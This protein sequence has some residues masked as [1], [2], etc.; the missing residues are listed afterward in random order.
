M[1]E[2]IGVSPG[3]GIGPAFILSDDKEQPVERAIIDRDVPR[4]IARFEEAIMT[5]RHQIKEIQEG[6]TDAIG[7]TDASILDAHLMVLDD[8]SFIEDVIVGLKKQLKNVETVVRLVA[9]KYADALSKVD[10]EYLRERAADIKDVARRILRNLHGDTYD[11][12]V[13]LE[14]KSLVVARD[15]APSEIAALRNDRVVG[16]ATDLGSRTSHTAIMARSLEI[17]AVMALRDVSTRV[18]SGDQVLID[19]NKGLLIIS[20]TEER[21][22]AYGQVV[23]AREHIRSELAG[24]R[25]EPA[26]TKD[27]HRIVLSA[28]IELPDDVDAALE[29]GANGVGLFRSEYLYLTREVLP[30]EDEQARAYGEVARRFESKPVIIRT[31][32]L[33]GDKIG[34]AFQI[35]RERNPFMGWRAIRFCLSHPAIFKTQLKAILRASHEGNVKLMYPMITSVEEVVDAN[36]ILEEA[37][38]ELSAAGVPFD[39]GM[40]VGV[41]IE[42]PSAALTADTIAPH[43]NFFSLGSNDLIQYTLAVDRGNEQIANLYKP[44]HPA[45]IKLIQHTI[46]V[47]HQYGIWVGLC[48]E[49]AADPLLTPLLLGLKIDELSVTPPALPMVKDAIRS[50]DYPAAQELAAAALSGKSAEHVIDLCRETIAR[51]APEILELV[52]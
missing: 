40:E 39:G 34:T 32:D 7:Q 5:T 49:M 45:I 26:E 27:G 43:V 3:V 51:T 29:H 9:K 13:V 19:G 23:K 22:Q 14:H 1:L 8:R 48:G 52:R 15:L 11:L 4:E 33:G 31:L 35:P 20:P 50:L 16:I 12:S 38:A 10:D 18:F 6:L 25:D 37:K 47:G 44:T 24:L 28:N 30:S 2:G 42:T 36:A 41:M 17:P 21:L 46:D